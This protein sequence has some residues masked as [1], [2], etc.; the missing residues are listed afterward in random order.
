MRQFLLPFYKARNKHG[1]A[2]IQFQAPVGSGARIWQQV[3]LPYSQQPPG[4][5]GCEWV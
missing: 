3:F 5:Q 4:R 2:V 1:M